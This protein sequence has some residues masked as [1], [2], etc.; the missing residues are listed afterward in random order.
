MLKKNLPKEH[1][2]SIE[3]TINY[4][5]KHLDKDLSLETLAEVANYSPFHFQKLFKDAV[6]DSPKQ[7]VKRMR[8]EVAAH[9]LVVHP[10]KP[11]SDIAEQTGFSSPAVFARAFKAYF[12]ITA[13][14]LRKLPHKERRKAMHNGN[15]HLKKLIGDRSPLEKP[16]QPKPMKVE[17]KILPAIS[18]ICLNTTFEDQSHIQ[19]GLTELIR[20]AKSHDLFNK[21]S[22][23]MGIIYPHHNIYRSFISVEQPELLPKKFHKTEIKPGKYASF[24]FKG[25]IKNAFDHITW[26]YHTWMPENGYKLADICGY[27]WFKGNPSGNAY[28]ETEREIYIPIEPV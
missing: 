8:L 21:N 9:Y 1:R 19:E 28:E 24:R 20:L 2:Q 26:F 18:G 7:Y 22:K 6:G 13:E 23:I 17:I 27:E 10:K 25:N 4:I 15:A 3:K 16:R 5:L 12:G 14:E 11:V